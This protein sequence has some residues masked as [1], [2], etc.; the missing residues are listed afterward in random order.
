MLRARTRFSI[1]IFYG[2][3][4]NERQKQAVRERMLRVQL[5][6]TYLQA[7]T[8]PGLKSKPLSEVVNDN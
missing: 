8:H 5:Q 7:N 3:K 4:V 1:N 2:L 6:I